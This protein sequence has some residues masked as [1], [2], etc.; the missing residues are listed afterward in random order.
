MEPIYIII[1]ALLISTANMGYKVCKGILDGRNLPSFF[2]KEEGKAFVR[3]TIWTL[4]GCAVLLLLWASMNLKGYL[5]LIH[6]A[7][8]FGVA[9]VTD[10]FVNRILL[11]YSGAAVTSVL[12]LYLWSIV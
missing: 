1:W 9:S 5:I 3:I 7:L 11:L 6:I 2:M 10:I 8:A 12:T 4:G